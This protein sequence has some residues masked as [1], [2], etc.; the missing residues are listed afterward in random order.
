MSLCS[1]MSQDA[2]TLSS[3][4]DDKASPIS[5]DTEIARVSVYNS[6]FLDR[7]FCLGVIGGIQLSS[8]SSLSKSY[9]RFML[10]HIA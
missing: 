8:R 9:L 1:D 10:W 6:E 3:F 2:S 4:F 7:P 5:K